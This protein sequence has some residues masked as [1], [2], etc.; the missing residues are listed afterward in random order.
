M[1]SVREYLQ[2]ITDTYNNKTF[3]EMVSN[4]YGSAGFDGVREQETPWDYVDVEYPELAVRSALEFI[5]P[6]LAEPELEI[7]EKW[8]SLYKQWISEGIFYKRYA[9]AMG[10]RFTWE[11]ERA[12]IAEW[13]GRNIPH[14][15]FWLWPPEL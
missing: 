6:E 14:S 15:H 11:D 12:T 5:R 4:M 1:D 2:E 10:G 8:D 3:S 7:L 13:L 9:L